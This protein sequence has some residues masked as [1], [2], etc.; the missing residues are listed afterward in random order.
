MKQIDLGEIQVFGR[1]EYT[2]A[3][4]RAMTNA[5]ADYMDGAEV[6]ILAVAPKSR[7][8]MID[9]G[10]TDDDLIEAIIKDQQ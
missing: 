5:T 9:A 8:E 4:Y 1:W 6:E 3:K 2:P 10:Y 7:E